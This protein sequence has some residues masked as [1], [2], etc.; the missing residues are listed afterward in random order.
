[1]HVSDLDRA[2]RFFIVEHLGAEGAHVLRGME[3][4]RFRAHE[5]RWVGALVLALL[6]RD[7]VGLGGPRRITLGG[8]RDV[9]IRVVMP[10]EWRAID[11][12]GLIVVISS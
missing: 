6:L 11:L 3:G 1:M 8:G 4:A 7:W 10:M 5:G 9:I 12:D 2:K